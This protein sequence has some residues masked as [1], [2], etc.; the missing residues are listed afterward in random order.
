MFKKLFTAFALSLVFTAPVHAAMEKVN[1]SWMSF[2]MK[3]MVLATT[4]SMVG[5]E[6]SLNVSLIVE[7][8]SQPTLSV[9]T[10]SMD[11]KEGE[12]YI[13]GITFGNAPFQKLAM[14]AISEH[15][16]VTDQIPLITDVMAGDTMKVQFPENSEGNKPISMFDLAGSRDA[17]L[18]LKDLRSTL[19]SQS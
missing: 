4:S 7:E 2:S 11:Y 5:R 1:G 8:G 10:D 16:L 18:R 6:S 13:V 3:N 19:L 15:M 9:Y 12:F 14:M 17:I